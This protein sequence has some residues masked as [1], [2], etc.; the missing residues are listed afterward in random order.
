[1]KG[2]RVVIFRP[3]A[4]G[5]MLAAAPVIWRIKELQPDTRI[6]YLAEEH[7]TAGTLSAAEV[8][9][10]IP[11]I[12]KVHL[13]SLAEKPWRRMRSLRRKLSPGPRDVL[14]YLCY[15]RYSIR[16]VLRDALFFRLIGFRTLRGFGAAFSDARSAAPREPLESEYDRLLRWA[17]GLI[18]G[19]ESKARGRLFTDECFADEFWRRNALAGQSVVALCVSSKMQAKRWPAERFVAVVRRL[20]P[21]FACAV[22]LIGGRGDEEIVAEVQRT[23]ADRCYS[24]LGASL[25]QT[26]A[27]LA[28]S[29]LYLGNDTGPMHLAGLLGVPCVAVFSDRDRRISWH[30]YGSDHMVL[31]RSVPCGGCLRTTCFASLPP[32]LDAIGVDEVLAAA[33]TAMGRSRIADHPFRQIDISRPC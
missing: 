29:V 5:D 27:L 9:R 21:E 19:K 31:R 3:G 11:E 25:P 12:E 20:Q 6:E 17:S 32:C 16:Q 18:R 1:M 24:A 2:K 22:V 23:I 7:A 4:L 13:Y 15:S 14:L 8:A 26:A 33:R 28:R 30:P 10:L